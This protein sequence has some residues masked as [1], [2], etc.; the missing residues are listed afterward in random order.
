M[1]NPRDHHAINDIAMMVDPSITRVVATSEDIEALIR[2]R[3]E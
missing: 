1:S 2:R 3:Q